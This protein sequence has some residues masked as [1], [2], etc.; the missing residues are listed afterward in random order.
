MFLS[1]TEKEALKPAPPT[2]TVEM[3]N[4]TVHTVAV[5]CN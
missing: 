2:V 5:G 3:S 1:E 4:P